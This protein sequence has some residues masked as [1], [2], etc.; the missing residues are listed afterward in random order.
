MDDS[1]VGHLV[2]PSEN[3]SPYKTI[4]LQLYKNDFLPYHEEQLVKFDLKVLGWKHTQQ[5]CM[6]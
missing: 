5:M 4:S 3:T 1:G 2:K 6:Q